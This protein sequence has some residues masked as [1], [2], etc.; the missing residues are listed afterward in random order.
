VIVRGRNGRV[1]G[2][3][4]RKGDSQEC[5]YLPLKQI[6]EHPENGIKTRRIQALY[7]VYS[8]PPLLTRHAP[9]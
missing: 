4:S 8:T 9:I 2:R 5:H 3:N 7:R 1:S 6:K